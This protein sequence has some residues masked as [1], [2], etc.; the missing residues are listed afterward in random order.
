MASLTGLFVPS[1]GVH[2]LLSPREQ[3][4]RVQASSSQKGHIGSG[5][6]GAAQRMVDCARSP[7]KFWLFSMEFYK[8]ME[9]YFEI[10]LSLFSW[11]ELLFKYEQMAERQDVNL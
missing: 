9:N 7:T 2:H 3:T 8:H 4:A 1:V 11:N 5:W 10:D 6:S